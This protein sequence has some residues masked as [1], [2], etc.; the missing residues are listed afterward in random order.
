MIVF[1]DGD[2]VKTANQQGVDGMEEVPVVALDNNREFEEIVPRKIYFQALADVLEPYNDEMDIS[3]ETFEQWETEQDFH[4]KVTFTHR[5]Q[6]WINDYLPEC[7]YRKPVVMR[8]A[9]DLADD[10]IDYSPFREMLDIMASKL[11]GHF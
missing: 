2:K 8:R 11:K 5:I 3:T 9:L 7:D 4:N 6:R 10:E 1:L